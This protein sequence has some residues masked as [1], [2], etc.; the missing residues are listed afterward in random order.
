MDFT[1]AFDYVVREVIWYKLIKIGVRGN[2]LNI[3]MS[4]YKHVKSKVK[5]NNSIS[6][7]FECNL[8]VRQG[9]MSVAI[10]FCYVHQ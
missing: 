4:M 5:I 9:G 6:I 10:S 8:G 3:I 1:K 2:I 7:G